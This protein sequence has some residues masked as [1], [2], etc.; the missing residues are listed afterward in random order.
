MQESVISKDSN[1]EGSIT[2][3][4]CM[5]LFLSTSITCNVFVLGIVH[6]QLPL[7][8]KYTCWSHAELTDTPFATLKN[9]PIGYIVSGLPKSES[10]K[11][12]KFE[13]I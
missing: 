7:V 2:N 4:P 3:T 5:Y 9:V 6:T 12:E 10:T 13:S 1:S 8:T 11:Y